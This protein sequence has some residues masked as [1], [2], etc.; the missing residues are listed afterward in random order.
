MAVSVPFIAT[1]VASHI[2]T[3]TVDN[4]QCLGILAEFLDCRIFIDI[5]SL[6]LAVI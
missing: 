4:P 1:T 3:N 5:T 6:S 2:M